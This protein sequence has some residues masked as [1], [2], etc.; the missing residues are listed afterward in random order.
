MITAQKLDDGVMS[1]AS[2]PTYKLVQM[3]REAVCNKLR[4]KIGC[5]LMYRGEDDQNT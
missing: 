1:L 5:E 3:S 4:D 2:I